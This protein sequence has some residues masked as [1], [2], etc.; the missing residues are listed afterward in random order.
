LGTTAGEQTLAFIRKKSGYNY[1]VENRRVD[2][3]VKQVTLLYL[4]YASSPEQALW[5][6]VND[7]WGSTNRYEGLLQSDLTVLSNQLSLE[8]TK[9]TIVWAH[10]RII[11]LA[12]YAQAPIAPPR[13]QN[14]DECVQNTWQQWLDMYGHELIKDILPTETPP[15][16]ARFQSSGSGHDETQV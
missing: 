13:C 4:G 10:K 12:D 8:Q 15:S 14:F 5:N 2:G 3:K 6:A 11:I 9:R 1:L 16:G 7:L